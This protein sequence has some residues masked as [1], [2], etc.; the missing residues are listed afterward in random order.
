MNFDNTGGEDYDLNLKMKAQNGTQC[1]IDYLNN[2]CPYAK[3]IRDVKV[4]EKGFEV[5][6]IEKFTNSQYMVYVSKTPNYSGSCTALT[7]LP[8][9][10]RLLKEIHFSKNKF[11]MLVE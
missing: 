7:R 10:N 3:K 4:G 6:E 11:R 2:E 5:L 1:K 8:A 9:Q